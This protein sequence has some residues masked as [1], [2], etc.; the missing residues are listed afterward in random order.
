MKSK[1][2]L[3]T[4]CTKRRKNPANL[5]MSQKKQTRDLR[6]L[7]SLIDKYY[8]DIVLTCLV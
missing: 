4:Y 7:L 1:T 3:S 6:A 8:S 2:R 5:E